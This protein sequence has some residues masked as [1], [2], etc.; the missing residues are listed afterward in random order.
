MTNEGGGSSAYVPEDRT[1][2]LQ[3]KAAIDLLH[4]VKVVSNAKP[5][6]VPAIE[7]GKAAVTPN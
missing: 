7:G 6:D 5:K 3:F 2:D 1:K 4:G